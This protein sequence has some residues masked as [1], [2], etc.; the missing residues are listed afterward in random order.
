MTKNQ[1]EK[2][3]SSIAGEY[4]LPKDFPFEKLK[5]EIGDM[6]VFKEWLDIRFNENFDIDVILGCDN[7]QTL[8]D[9]VYTKLNDVNKIQ[10]TKAVKLKFLNTEVLPDDIGFLIIDLSSNDTET[11]NW[12]DV[13]DVV[14]GLFKKIYRRNNIDYRDADILGNDSKKIYI[15]YFA[16]AEADYSATYIV[17]DGRLIFQF[18]N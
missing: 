13:P 6:L 10:N 7:I 18:E 11:K 3:V 15:S 4:L 16:D 1:V 2:I 14:V 9:Y 8:S 12:N 17:Y 5:A